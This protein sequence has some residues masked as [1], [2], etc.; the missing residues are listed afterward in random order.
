MRNQR[1]NERENGSYSTRISS[2]VSL[3]NIGTTTS[4][5]EAHKMMAAH[6]DA[7]NEKSGSI[8]VKVDRPSLNAPTVD[9]IE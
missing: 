2:F 3:A 8:K 7:Q 5:K 6:S 9:N 4:E 1:R